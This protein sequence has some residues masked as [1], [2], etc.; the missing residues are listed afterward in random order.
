[1]PKIDNAKDKPRFLLEM[2]YNTMKTKI[3]KELQLS[4]D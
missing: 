1:M 2:Q 4:S 3:I